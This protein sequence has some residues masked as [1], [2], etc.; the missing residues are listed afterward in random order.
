MSTVRLL[1]SIKLQFNCILLFRNSSFFQR[2]VAKNMH[3]TLAVLVELCL[4]IL[5]LLGN[6]LFPA[7]KWPWVPLSIDVTGIE[8][9]ELRAPMQQTFDQLDPLHEGMIL[10]ADLVF[11][12][13]KTSA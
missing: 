13:S 3:G 8:G 9:S 2:K 1:T 6:R 11:P 4:L 7:F 10:I 12:E 5:A